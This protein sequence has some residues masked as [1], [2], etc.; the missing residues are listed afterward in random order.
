VVFLISKEEEMKKTIK[1]FSLLASIALSGVAMPAL[2]DTAALAAPT[3]TVNGLV[4]GYYAYNFTN[5]SSFTTGSYYFYNTAANNFTLGLAEVKVTATQGQGS[6]HLVLADSFGL[7][8]GLSG[9]V[10]VLQAYVSYNPDKWTISAGRFVAWMGYEVIE[11]TGNWN[12]S[13]SLLFGALPY[14]H[15]GV[16]VAY[17]P[18]S[19]FGI[20]FYDTDTTWN[21]STSSSWGKTLGLQAAI[22]P[23]SM[24]SI[25]L[26]GIMTPIG[27]GQNNITAEG[28]VV[29]KPTSEWSFALDGQ[30]GTNSVSSGNAPSYFGVALYG[31]YQFQSDWSAALRAE[32]VS[33][34]YNSF[35]FD[36]NSLA[37]GN[38]FT[39][40]EVTLTVAH[41]FTSNLVGSLE[42]RMDMASYN[43]A[44]ANI[45]P[46]GSA[47]PSSSNLTGTASLAMTF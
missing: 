7:I 11:S 37:A 31:K 38:A 25:I 9:D 30:F 19:T 29:Y 13:H 2:A 5:P 3:V 4:D 47:S 6:A 10:D 43:S 28:I 36:G 14:W 39:G 17:A 33:D 40:D 35:G 32:Y 16:S 41:N 26:N 20:T 45:F 44:A 22:N 8:S 34:N 23:N 18:D 12:Y 24:W 15:T 21:S 46:N 1:L 42:G 27:L